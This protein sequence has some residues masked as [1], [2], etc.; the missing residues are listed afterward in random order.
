MLVIRSYSFPLQQPQQIPQ[1]G[2]ANEKLIPG[3]GE[4]TAL[5]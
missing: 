1:P 5:D 2:V 3:A 4:Y